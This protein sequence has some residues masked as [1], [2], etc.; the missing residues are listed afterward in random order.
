MAL[1]WPG[2]WES[3]SCLRPGQS[4]GFQAKLGRKSTRLMPS[5]SPDK[6]SLF[7]STLDTEPQTPRTIPQDLNNMSLEHMAPFHGD[8]E[9]KNPENFLRLFFWCMGTTSD[10]TKNSSSCYCYVIVILFPISVYF[11]DNSFWTYAACFII[12]YCLYLHVLI[13]ESKYGTSQLLTSDSSCLILRYSSSILCW[14]VL[15]TYSNVRRNSSGIFYMQIVS[16]TNGLMTCH[17]M[18]KRTGLP[19]KPHFTSGGQERRQQRKQ[20]RNMRRKLWV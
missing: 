12:C 3:Q 9:D 7:K 14:G 4:R 10:N 8:K 2:I 19:S 11:V 5:T 15:H 16:Q 17:R 13:P 18:K 1:A 6:S 20:Q